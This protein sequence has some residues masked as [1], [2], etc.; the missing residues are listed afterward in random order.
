MKNFKYFHLFL[1]IF[2]NGCV[3]GSQIVS[4]NKLFKGMTKDQFSNKFLFAT[5]G[6][7][8]MLTK[9]DSFSYFNSS[10]NS[11]IIW[12]S[13]SRI[14]Y[15]FKNV[16]VP[17]KCGYWMCNYGNG[18]YE[19]YFYALNKAKEYINPVKKNMTITKE[20]K[21]AT[22]EVKTTSSVSQIVRLEKLVK[23]FENGEISQE[24]FNKKKKEIIDN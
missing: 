18:N 16:T 17:V 1:F 7:S 11:E 22:I 2:I 8:P 12:G 4:D 3:S 13:N 15:V 10:T 6:E 5:A 23:Q 21:K 9:N 14:F 19:T 20:N 24:E